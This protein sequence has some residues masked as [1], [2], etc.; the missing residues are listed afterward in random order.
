MPAAD[1]SMVAEP[2]R[3]LVCYALFMTVHEQKE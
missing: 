1:S 3:I 2:L